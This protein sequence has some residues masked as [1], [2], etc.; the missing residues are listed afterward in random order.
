MLLMNSMVKQWFEI[1]KTQAHIKK[2]IISSSDYSVHFRETTMRSPDLYGAGS[3]AAADRICDNLVG[4]L[5][6]K[7]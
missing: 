1:Q 5:C 6:I 4:M 2:R 3:M 7:V